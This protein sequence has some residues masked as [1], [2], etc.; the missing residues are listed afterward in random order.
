VRS[1]ERQLAAQFAQ[2]NAARADLSPSFRLAGSIGLEALSLAKL[3]V[4]GGLAWSASPSVSTRVFDRRQL[5]E[6]VVVQSERQQQAALTYETRVL[7][8][9][10]EVEDS[11]VAVAQER[12]RRDRLG[13]ATDAAQQA[14]DLSLQL[15]NTGLRDFRDVLDAQRSL[16]TLQDSLASSDTIVSSDLVRLFKAL[17]GGWSAT[18]M[19]PE[20]V[21]S[22]P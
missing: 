4:P 2:V 12:V 14:A 19:L 8:A 6:N 10:Q 5:R 13:S 11:L 21:T 9:L 18:A 22:S 1:A 16:L 15:Y 17:G 3:F 20:Q 7:A